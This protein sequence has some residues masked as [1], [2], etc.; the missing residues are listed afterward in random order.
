MEKKFIILSATS[1]MLKEKNTRVRIDNFFFR[2]AG[3][4]PFA[5]SLAMS[6]PNTTEIKKTSKFL[7]TAR[8][9]MMTSHP[10]KNKKI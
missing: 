10:V 2:G 9:V 7:L 8:K 5:N 3:R 1:T 4:Y 6:I